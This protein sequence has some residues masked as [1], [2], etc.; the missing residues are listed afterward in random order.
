VALCRATAT[1]RHWPHTAWQAVRDELDGAI[2]IDPPCQAQ[3]EDVLTTLTSHGL[4]PARRPAAYPA[5]NRAQVRV[6]GWDPRLLR[7]RLAVLLAGM[8]SPVHRMGRDHRTHPVSLRPPRR[9]SSRHRPRGPRPG[10]ARQHRRRNHATPQRPTPPHRTRGQRHRATPTTHP[11]RHRPLRRTH[12][13]AHPTRRKR[14]HP[15]PHATHHPQP[16]H[17]P[18]KPPSQHCP[19]SARTPSPR[20]TGLLRAPGTVGASAQ[21]RPPL[22]HTEPAVSA[23]TAAD[24]LR[25]AS[26]KPRPSHPLP[27]STPRRPRTSTPGG[28]SPAWPD[29]EN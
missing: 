10:L 14:H 26:P 22:G 29:P 6:T 1:A 19:P 20:P 5:Q 28:A 4:A 2:I 9:G 8:G 21:Q 27:S 17:R 11:R 13:R 7:R 24:S 16:R 18:N 15:L 25:S 3:A 23:I 12:R